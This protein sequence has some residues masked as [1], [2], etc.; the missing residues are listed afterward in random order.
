MQHQ[1][2]FL[3]HLQFK[4][5]VFVAQLKVR[6]DNG[7]NCN[8]DKLLHRLIEWTTSEDRYDRASRTRRRLNTITSCTSSNCQW[9]LTRVFGVIKQKM[10][11]M[12]LTRNFN[13]NHELPVSR[14]IKSV[15]N[16]I[17][18]AGDDR[19]GERT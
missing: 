14:S 8:N 18:R 7:T 4:G 3:P 10:P 11:T 13:A 5:S 2:N 12:T 17:V 1:K 6:R 9:P 16:N 19:L 15:V